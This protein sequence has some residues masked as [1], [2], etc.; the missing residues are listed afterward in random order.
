MIL[1]GD[2]H[3]NWNNLGK[4]L[5]KIQNETIIQVGDFG[6]FNGNDIAE[7]SGANKICIRNNIQLKAIRGNHSNPKYFKERNYIH[8]NIELLPDYTKINNVLLIGGATSVDRKTR[9]KGKDWF[10]DEVL[11]YQPPGEAEILVCHTGPSDVAMGNSNISF[12]IERDEKLR[13]D[14]SKEQEIILRLI[15][16]T[17][18]KKMF[19]GHFHMSGCC[20]IDDCFCRV[21]DIEEAVEIR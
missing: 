6:I 15:K 2:I 7:L 21:L 12:W 19:F 13:P 14:L 5:F 17:G 18:A 1:L 20:Q 16:G 11:T 4:I 10:P 8:S 3:G 9:E